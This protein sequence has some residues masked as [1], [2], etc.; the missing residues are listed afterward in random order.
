MQHAVAFSF[1]IMVKDFHEGLYIII[2]YTTTGIIWKIQLCMLP[3][4][5]FA[6]KKRYSMSSM[7]L[8]LFLHL[9]KKNKQTCI[10]CFFCLD[11][12]D[13]YM[14]KQT[15]CKLLLCQRL[16]PCRWSPLKVMNCASHISWTHPAGEPQHI[17]PLSYSLK[18]WWSSC[19]FSRQRSTCWS[20][21][22]S[23]TSG[24]DHPLAYILF[25]GILLL[26]LS[27]CV[28]VS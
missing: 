20:S 17:D 26:I 9:S 15:N 10:V 12:I 25:V 28:R 5:G 7:V 22:L 18:V 2:S 11:I 21:F 4:L 23:R 24:K 14:S 3:S 8:Q 27:F 19:L 13:N 16:F 6:K 1:M